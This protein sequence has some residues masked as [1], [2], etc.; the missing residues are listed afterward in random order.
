[1]KHIILLSVILLHMLATPE[2]P[3]ALLVTLR[4]A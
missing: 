2:A 4:D 1:M 3:P